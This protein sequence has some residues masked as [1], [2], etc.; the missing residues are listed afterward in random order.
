MSHVLGVSDMKR[1]AVPSGWDAGELVKYELADGTTY[2]DLVADIAVMLQEVQADIES[3]P[4]YGSLVSFTTEQALEYQN[5]TGT[6]G[7]E[8]RTENR[9][10]DPRKS[11]TIGHMLPLQSFDRQMT[12]TWDFLRKAR[13]AQIDSDLISAKYDVEDEWQ[14]RVLKRFFSSAENQ[15]GSSGYDMPLA[16]ASSTVAYTPPAYN[17]KTF[18]SS[19]THFARVA[20]ASRATGLEAGILSLR[21]HGIM[22]PYVGILPQAYTATWAALSNW[23]K[24]DRAINH[25]NGATDLMT[26]GMSEE[27]FVGAY[28][29]QY[30]LIYMWETPRLSADYIGVYKTFGTN[31]PRN[32]VAI[33]YSEDLGAQ[34]I[35]M[36]GETRRQFPLENA[37]IIHEYGVGISGAERMARLNGYAIKFDSSGDYTDPTIS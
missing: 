18:A 5:G 35:L 8:E 20:A 34:P 36:A 13:R 15:Q 14:R 3:N 33:R 9:S 7:M 31:D 12:W 27:M 11:K 29:S 4:Q 16:N 23:V 6:T 37:T 21:E 17:G 22:G 32:P 19:H 2:D 28:N 26:L 25:F 1:F 24:P 10:A 30:G